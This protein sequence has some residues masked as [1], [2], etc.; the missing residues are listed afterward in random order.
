M[1]LKA[2]ISDEYLKKLPIV[3]EDIR[4]CSPFDLGT[5]GSKYTKGFV[6]IT[7]TDIFVQEN[8]DSLKTY[9]LDSIDKISCDALVDNGILVISRDGEDKIIARFSM[10]YLTKFSYI[11]RSVMSNFEGGGPV[12]GRE[13]ESVC[14]KC[15]KALPGTK[16]C[17]TCKGR[18][19]SL[20]KIWEVTKPY[21]LKLLAISLFM[22][23]GAV[24]ALIGP[25]IQKQFIDGHLKPMQGTT[26]DILVF[27]FTMLG[28]TILSIIL[29]LV[30]NWWCTSLG[31]KISM[32]LRA[33]MYRRLQELSL[34]F[35]NS[36][37]PGDL[38]NYIVG[39]VG[40]VRRFLEDVFGRMFST[41]FTM[42][43]AFFMLLTLNWKLTLLS[44]AFMPLTWV[45]NRMWRR[46]IHRMFRSQRM[47]SDKLNSSLQDVIMGMR[48]VKSFGKEKKEAERFTAAAQELAR[49]QIRNEVFWAVFH[50]VLVFIMGLG[51]YIITF[52]G[53]NSVL[54]GS[55]SIGELNQFIAY[56][57]ILYGPLEW[58]VVLPRRLTRMMTALERIYDVLDEEP[59][60][61]DAPD[62]K[63]H[64]I[65]G[66]VSF[67]NVSFGYK[68]YDPVLTN[69]SFDV[70]N[71]EMIGLVGESGA[72]KSTLINLLMRL[73]IPDSGSIK[74]D[75][76]N[77]E[78]ISSQSLHSQI[79]VV[80]QET[81][82]FTGT[83]INNIRYA[84]PTAT[85]EEVITA[86][87]MANAHDFICKM[88]DGYNTY[89]G[90]RGYT[91]SGGERQ[92]IAIARAILNNPK[93]LILDE[94][95]SNLDTESEFLIQNALER[96]TGGRTTFAIAHRLSTLRSAD[97]IFVIDKG[98][99]AESGSHNELMRK[100]GIYYGLVMAQLT[101]Q[102]EA[103]SE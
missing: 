55:M 96:L 37:K 12:L 21:A 80:L 88:P 27:V 97:R 94:A 9:P 4:F 24:L 45:A 25:E 6:S 1:N 98:G 16:A 92:R 99:I 58:L 74:I 69:V 15:G 70:K 81:F 65:V 89:V 61:V 29:A 3:R 41:L 18:L 62:A 51:A 52:Y 46:R 13:R 75:G 49:I 40:E 79:G 32:D 91:L 57:A 86:A 23:I 100:K 82:L 85:Y 2:K 72:G 71:G 31:A 22:I 95:T 47:K 103:P 33:R 35:M 10:K 38:M 84:K 93:L 14:P 54:G 36:R 78:D 42:A 28:I 76:I 67:E 53:G 30:R 43:G 101:M 64:D 44:V 68:A 56:S 90:E 7:D 77:I 60:I 26:G 8:A 39:D 66:D 59:E 19:D 5:H 17:P 83:V 34:S 87:K 48:V 11:A 73:Y 50:P 102:K 63:A 20:R